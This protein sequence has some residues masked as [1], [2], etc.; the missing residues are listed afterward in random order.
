MLNLTCYTVQYLC[1]YSTY[2]KL[3]KHNHGIAGQ[4]ESSKESK[5]IF[6]VTAEQ[7]IREKSL[8]ITSS[9]IVWMPE[10]FFK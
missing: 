7:K 5:R 3:S 2:A 4:F 1:L 9:S 10:Y 6:V 8:L